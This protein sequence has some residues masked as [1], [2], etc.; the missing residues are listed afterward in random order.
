[1]SGGFAHIPALSGPV[2][3]D[4]EHVEPRVA[5]RLESLVQES[6]FFD[7]PAR[8]DTKAKGAADYRTYTITVQ[9]GLRVHTVELTD[10]INDQ[11]L[12]T[13]VSFLQGMSR[14]SAR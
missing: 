12:G 13:L 7:Q 5:E 10:P 14:P 11:N 8:L 1:M 9:D 2:T 4:T 6:C 3:T